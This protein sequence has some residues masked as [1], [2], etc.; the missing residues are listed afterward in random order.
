MS[1][2]EA[3]QLAERHLAQSLPRRW[4]HVQAVA[5]AAAKIG[6]IVGDDAPVLVAAAW[7]H[8]I[9]YAPDVVRTGF[10]PL[11]GARH[12]RALG[13][14][15]R[16]SAL[17]AHHTGASIEAEL[18]GLHDALHSEFAVEESVTADALWYADLT[19]DPDGQTLS[20][21]E[22]LAEIRARYGP[23]D[24]VTQFINRAE[25]ALVAAVNRTTERITTQLPVL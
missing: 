19:T 14:S 20:V 8:D 2:E 3:Q 18:R 1:P 25:S 6:P 10:H 9:G 5:N 15:P 4:R 24:I 12:L 7:L 21:N 13:S 16:L 11:D 22:R 23:E 17:V